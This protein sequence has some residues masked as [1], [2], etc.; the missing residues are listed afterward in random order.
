VR[1]WGC[2]ATK[3]KGR[4]R[5][6][7]A[8]LA[9]RAARWRGR[10]LA[11]DAHAMGSSVDG[12][13]CV[14]LAE[15]S[16]LGVG[17]GVFMLRGVMLTSGTVELDGPVLKVDGLLGTLWDIECEHAVLVAAF[18]SVDGEVGVLDEL[19]VDKLVDGNAPGVFVDTD[20]LV[21]ALGH[22]AMPS[23][24]QDSSGFGHASE[25]SAG[26][27]AVVDIDDVDDSSTVRVTVTTTV[28]TL[29]ADITSVVTSSCMEALMLGTSPKRAKVKQGV[30]IV[31]LSLVCG[32]GRR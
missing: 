27:N 7:R 11:T 26:D 19:G 2:A 3:S 17:M 31:E 24:M 29:P 12:M 16:V 10:A 8:L 20:K 1:G 4:R 13:V 32:E 15:S 23:M 14:G 28:S 9:E 18:V 30:Y 6:A 25:G 22:I 5:W 21:V